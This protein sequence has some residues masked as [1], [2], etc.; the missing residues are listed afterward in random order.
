MKCPFELLINKRFLVGLIVSGLLLSGVLFFSMPY[1]AMWQIKTA[2]EEKDSDRL[3]TYVDFPEL[4]KNIKVQLKADAGQVLQKRLFDSEAGS[5]IGNIFG[6]FV[7]DQ[8]VDLLVT[9]EGLERLLSGKSALNFKKQSELQPVTASS[10]SEST[11]AVKT[12]K[13]ES[14]T[15]NSLGEFMVSNSA[16]D[17][18]V[19]L[20][21]SRQGVFSWK[22]T[23]ILLPVK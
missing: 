23:N 3:A 1:Y 9:P 11:N 4:R 18:E 20:V 5:S 15:W 6:G 21:L 8:L 16:K 13:R 2:A 17:E 19:T 10:T 22:L 12:K 14:F 7:A